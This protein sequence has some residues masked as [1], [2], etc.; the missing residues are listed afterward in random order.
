LLSREYTI[1]CPSS[2]LDFVRGNE[3]VIRTTKKLGVPTD[4]LLKVFEGG[5]VHVGHA[6]R[7]LVE[8]FFTTMNIPM[9]QR[10]K[11]NDFPFP[12]NLYSG[13]YISKDWTHQLR[14]PLNR[15]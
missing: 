12:S 7:G 8:E 13:F 6:H 2:L 3:A 9:E 14:E 15:R 11:L 10:R 4:S 5:H 1:Y